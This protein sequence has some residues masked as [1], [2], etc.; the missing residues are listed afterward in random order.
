MKLYTDNNIYVNC[1]LCGCVMEIKSSF[2]TSRLT[3]MA[4]IKGE[5]NE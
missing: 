5:N 3:C 2:Y 4:C 1:Y